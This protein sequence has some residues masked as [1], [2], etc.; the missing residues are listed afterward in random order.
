MV[1]FIKRMIKEASKKSIEEGQEKYREYFVY[2]KL[3]KRYKEKVDN[4]LITDGYENV[5]VSE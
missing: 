5:I 3:Y 2:T 4:G 1:D